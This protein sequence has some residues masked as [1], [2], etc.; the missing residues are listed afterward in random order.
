[1]MNDIIK[2]TATAY[3]VK[4][5]SKRLKV[6][7]KT[8]LNWR[9]GKTKPSKENFAKL[10]RLNQDWIKQALRQPV[11]KDLK[12]MSLFSGCGGMDL[13]FEGD[14]DVLSETINPLIHPEWLPAE[15]RTNWVRLPA[16]RFKTIF[17]NDICRAGK[18]AWAPHFEKRGAEKNYYHL[19]SIVSLVKKH[20]NGEFNF[21]DAD[22]VTGGFPCQD[23]SVA[24]KRKGFNSSKAHHGDNF[25][26]DD[27]PTEEN[28][29]KLYVW[30]RHV[31]EIVR[32]KIFIA[33]NVKGLASLSNVK[34]IIEN[35]FRNVGS[36]YLV[37]PAKIL[38]A[39]DYGVPQT[40]ERIIFIGFRKDAL[41]SN[42]LKAFSKDPVP[43]DFDPYPQKTHGTSFLNGTL[44]SYV[45]VKHCFKDLP[46]PEESLDP[47]QRTYS[48]AKWYG[49]H[50]QGQNEVDL[51]KPGPTI[52]SEHHGN[53]E[54]RR[55][56]EKHGGKHLDE[57]ANGLKERRL[58]IRECARI[59]TFPDDFQFVRD[60]KELGPEFKL[61]GSEAYKII[62][63]AV[64]PLLAMHLA[65][66]LQEMWPRIIKEE[67]Q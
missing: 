22:I 56:S 33:E 13:G 31:V 57:L 51:N 52:R 12:V 20:K 49:R 26:D 11:I 63:N 61:S 39:P 53:I 36:G 42:A 67:L 46:E 54:F 35:D 14:F 6:R 41:N 23:F 4:E 32:P 65:W 34:E 7:E 48:K 10:G 9:K 38:Y 64:P 37:S 24:G 45:P 66:R 1:M 16:T 44:L 19:E 5:L 40:R 47:S 17:A 60:Q 62:G 3:G 30:M 28:R 8:V 2:E 58:T 27:N 50:C 59:Q 25:N 29:G 21:P 15:N 18:A 43:K 55:L